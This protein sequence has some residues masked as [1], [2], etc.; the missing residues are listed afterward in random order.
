MIKIRR[1]RNRLIFNIITLV[2]R[3]TFYIEAG[4]SSPHWWEHWVA[5]EEKVMETVFSQ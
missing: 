3:K 5:Y 2:P 1:Y 4:P